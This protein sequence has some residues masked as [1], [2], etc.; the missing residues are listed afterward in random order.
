MLLFLTVCLLVPQSSNS[1]F[2]TLFFLSYSSSA[3]PISLPAPDHSRSEMDLSAPGSE[4]SDDALS[5]RSRSVPGLNET[6]SHINP[7]SHIW[8]LQQPP[9]RPQSQQRPWDP[10][11]FQ[12][13]SLLNLYIYYTVN[14]YLARNLW[15]NE[16][17]VMHQMWGWMLISSQSSLQRAWRASKWL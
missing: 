8:F 13:M 9:H 5:L 12:L 11:I 10:L 4:P 16:I 2:E 3:L 1:I 6:V 15:A 7:W 14:P 17:S